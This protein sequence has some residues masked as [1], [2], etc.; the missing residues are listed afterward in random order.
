MT[1]KSSVLKYCVLMMLVLLWM[2]PMRIKAASIIDTDVS[3]AKSGNVLRGLEGKYVTEVSQAVALINSYRKEACEKGYENPE[4]GRRL[5]ASDYVPIRW[6]TDLEYIARI[7]AAEAALTLDHVRTNKTSCFNLVSPGG[8]RSGGE[9]LAW[10]DSTTSMTYGI[11]QWYAEKNDWVKKNRSAV[12]GHYEVMITPSNRYVGLGSFIS[13]QTYFGNCTAGEFSKLTG[14]SSAAMSNPG[15]VIQM[16]ELPSRCIVSSGREE[17][18]AL[19]SDVN[20]ERIADSGYGVK[21]KMYEKASA[22]QTQSA[23]A[24][25]ETGTK[26]GSAAGTITVTVTT[27]KPAGGNASGSVKSATHNTSVPSGSVKN[28]KY[29]GWFTFRRSAA[30]ETQLE[31]TKP[32]SKNSAK[33]VIPDTLTVK[34]VSYKVTSIGKNAFSGCKKLNTVVIGKHIRQ[35]GSRAFYKCKNLR[36]ITVNTPLLTRQTMGKQAFTGTHKKAAF[37]V[38]KGKKKAYASMLRS[39]GASKKATCK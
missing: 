37:K 17:N 1:K 29:N 27:A 28:V 38:P 13:E 20:T 22:Q 9:V 30:G 8:V 6:S 19:W 39:A 25:T 33:A 34:G 10:N 24:Q 11:R 35:I 31:F 32:I 23:D 4:T 16:L 21:L 2:V 26:S 12:T 18:G 3:K 36:R 5:T 7:R 14:L 15:E